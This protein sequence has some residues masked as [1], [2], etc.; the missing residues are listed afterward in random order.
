MD[1][2]VRSFGGWKKSKNGGGEAGEV[3]RRGAE[4]QWRGGGSGGARWTWQCGAWVG[5]SKAKMG[6][7]KR[8]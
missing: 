2:A 3:R 5:G 7:G 8:M 1:M 6:E 4:V